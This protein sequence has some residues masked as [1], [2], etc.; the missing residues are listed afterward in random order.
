MKPKNHQNVH[1]CLSNLAKKQGINFQLLSQ[2]FRE[3]NVFTKQV[4]KELISRN[5]SFGE[6]KFLVFSHCVLTY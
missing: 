6:S 2:N 3:S 5:I 1:F 4:T